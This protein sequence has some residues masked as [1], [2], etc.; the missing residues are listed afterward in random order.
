[1]KSW[2]FLTGILLAVAQTAQGRAS[3]QLSRSKCNACPA[4]REYNELGKSLSN[5]AKVYFPCSEGFADAKARWSTLAAPD[6]K[7]VV[8]PGIEQDVAATVKFAN[9]AHMPFMAVTS[10]HGTPITQGRMK[11]G[12][13]I[14]MH[15]LNSVELIRGGTQ[16][17]VGGGVKAGPFN[18]GLWAKG[19]QAGKHIFSMHKLK[20]YPLAK[21]IVG[22]I[23]T[24]GAS[25]WRC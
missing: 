18:Q 16:A 15:Q 12:I 8:L 1:M 5:K 23:H 10:G 21:N 6:V 4:T 25:H 14:R 11:N 22:L 7:I 3:P 24:V 9:K 13:E 20:R 19:K 2:V 17:R